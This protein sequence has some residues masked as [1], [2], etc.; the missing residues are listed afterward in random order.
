MCNATCGR[1]ILISIFLL[2]TSVRVDIQ[3]QQPATQQT[4]NTSGPGSVFGFEVAT[5][6]PA[7][8][9][10]D[11]HTHINYPAGGG[12][13]SINIPL[14]ALMQWAYD[15]QEER[16]LNQPAWLTSQSFDIQA[17]TDA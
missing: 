16:I 4:A 14:S 7:A 10:P 5:V 2:C 13:S 15:V 12:F 9:S 17:K 8:P 6:K 11:G 3:A 1:I